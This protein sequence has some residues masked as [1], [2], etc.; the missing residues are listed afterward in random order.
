M[1]QFNR[2]A[3]HVVQRKEDWHLNNQREAATQRVDLFCF[4]QGHHFL[5]LTLFV[6]AQTLTHCL[7]L[8]LQHAHLRHGGVLRF[9][10]RV[11]DA[12]NDKGD[13]DD[14]EAPVAEEAVDEFQQLKQRLGDEPQPTVVDGQIQVRRDG[15]HFV[16]NGRADPQNAFQLVGLTRLHQYRLRFIADGDNAVAEVGGVEVVGTAVLRNPCGGEV[17]LQHRHPTVFGADVQVFVIDDGIEFIFFVFR[18]RR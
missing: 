11:H 2:G 4:I 17:L 13:N 12:T 18:F 16:L 6:I 7:N 10:Q 15:C 5:A 3:Q 14:R 1:T 8:R 9:G